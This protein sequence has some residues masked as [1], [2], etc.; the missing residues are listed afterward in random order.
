MKRR[1]R[2]DEYDQLH[3]A[4]QLNVKEIKVPLLRLYIGPTS[5]DDFNSLNDSECDY[6]R[7][8]NVEGFE[9]SFIDGSWGCC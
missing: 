9:K 5:L 7:V 2:K 1:N 3:A 8:K 4:V 6:Y